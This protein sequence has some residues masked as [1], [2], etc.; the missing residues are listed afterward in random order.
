MKLKCHNILE[1]DSLQPHFPIAS[2]TIQSPDL[3]E[4]FRDP[5]NK[6]KIVEI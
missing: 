2:E 6:V 3:V 5:F 1:S 4:M